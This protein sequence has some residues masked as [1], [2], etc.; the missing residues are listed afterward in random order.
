VLRAPLPILS[1]SAVFETRDTDQRSPLQKGWPF[2]VWG[3]AL[4]LFN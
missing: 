2:L 1:Q 4:S 3:D